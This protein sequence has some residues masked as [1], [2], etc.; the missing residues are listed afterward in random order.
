[1]PHPEE[2]PV[3]TQYWLEKPSDDATSFRCWALLES[4]RVVGAYQF[5][6]TP[7]VETTV[8]VKAK[9]Y[10]RGKIDKL[11]I[12]PITS[13][14]MWGGGTKP[15]ADDPR[16]EV[17]DADGLFVLDS[18]NM[19]LWRPLSRPSAPIV[20]HYAVPGLKAFGL[21]Q[22]ARDGKSYADSEAL[23]HRRPSILIEPKQAWPA[24][25][26]ELLR[27]PAAHEG[28][29]NIGAF[30]LL[31]NP[32]QEGES[33]EVEYRIHVCDDDKQIAPQHLA[34]S[35]E[36]EAAVARFIRSD[37]S[38][39][40]P[41]VWRIN[42]IAEVK[43]TALERIEEKDLSDDMISLWN[44]SGGIIQK[45]VSLVPDGIQ[46][47]FEIKAEQDEA[48]EL[49]VHLHDTKRVL[50]ERWSYRCEP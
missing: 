30:Y 1:M 11:G 37:V 18:N 34:A 49:L 22:R 26:V 24:G 19:P 35:S 28:I 32:P 5:D 36:S 20:N 6:I 40:E 43:G 38:Q 33:I 10:I 17:H 42:L 44:Q 23:Y 47:A 4:E 45:K 48:I 41:G 21:V 9:L 7:D 8:D 3:F 27:L 12:A 25:G 16:P 29:D 15:P 31:R 13:M 39:S 46:V 14:W 2:F 50:T